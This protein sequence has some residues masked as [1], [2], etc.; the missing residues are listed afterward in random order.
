MS[1]D[2]IQTPAQKFADGHRQS[3]IVEQVEDDEDLFGSL[4]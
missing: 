4:T 1:V 2:K 3:S